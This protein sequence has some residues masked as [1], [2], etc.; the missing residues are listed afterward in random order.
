[1]NKPISHVLIIDDNAVDNFSH[2]RTIDKSGLV[3]SV[4]VCQ[5]ATEALEILRDN[6]Q[7]VDII[8]LD[9]HMPRMN[10]FE[11]LA[12]YADIPESCKARIV[13]IMLSSYSLSKEQ[14]TLIADLVTKCVPK[15]ITIEI[16]EQL[17]KGYF[18]S[19]AA[20]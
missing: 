19:A 6:V 18:P 10:G 8:F 17:A 4:T 9:I 2:Q 1:M 3:E 14:Q 20:E 13:V 15:P 5:H 16:M 11:F 12:E 7:P